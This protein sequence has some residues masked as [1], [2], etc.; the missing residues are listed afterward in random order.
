[1]RLAAWTAVL[2]TGVATGA[3]TC[4][5]LVVRR[6]RLIVVGFA[7]TASTS[8]LLA[9]CLAVWQE[10]Q[11]ADAVVAAGFISMGACIGGYALATALLPAVTRPR[12]SE[13]ALSAP[14]PASA[15]LA[16][17]LLSDAEPEQ[18]DPRAIAAI[19]LR[20]EEM[21]APLPPELAKP[22]VYTAERSRYERTGGSP[23]RSTVTSI[24]RS[25]EAALSADGTGAVVVPAFCDGGPSVSEALAGLVASGHRRVVIALLS[26]ARTLP[27]VTALATI[28]SHEATAA[29]VQVEIADPLWSSQGLVEMIAARI[30]EAVGA[31]VSHAGV[32]LV[33]PGQPTELER[34]GGQAA[35]QDTYFAERLRSELMDAGV[36]SSRIRRGWLQWEE[37]DVS[38]AARHLAA[39]GAQRIV[40]VP[41]SFPTETIQTLLDLRYAADANSAD[42]ATGS[43]VLGAWGND[44]A[45]VRGLAD[46]INTA[47]QR[48]SEPGAGAS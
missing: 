44:A 24:A 36:T 8:A 22:L 16:V 43:V 33:E 48:M 38:E 17:V 15:E 34:G 40:F 35:E 37:P 42:T 28:N 30:R 31:E 18:Y 29:G 47:T 19:L 45:L 27:F 5:A 41:V 12:V 25:L 1:V 4:A 14:E 39:V 46:A 11:R 23:A 26:V 9:S 32:C 2:L 10:S 13:F 6:N 7:A 20:H 3:M 21:G